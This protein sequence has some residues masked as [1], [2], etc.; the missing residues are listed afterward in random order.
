MP[1]RLQL[2]REKGFNLQAWSLG[3]NGLPAVNV[4]RPH[5]FGNPFRVGMWL[6]F[7]QADAVKAHANW[8][9]WEP[10]SRSC[11]IAFGEPPDVSD[12]RGKNLACW[13]KPYDPCHA[14][15]L[16]KLANRP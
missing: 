5:R 2:S 10:S 6:N 9:A 11:N 15:T 13:C 1:V 8:M 12:L 16:L 7:S 14:D 3:I 4:A